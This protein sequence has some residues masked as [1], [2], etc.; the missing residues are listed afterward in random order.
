LLD[1][2]PPKV[3]GGLEDACEQ[4][5]IV[6]TKLK[7]VGRRCTSRLLVRWLQQRSRRGAPFTAA[8]VFSP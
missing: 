6:S 4:S 3:S 7:R 5:T 1:T 2:P 8:Q